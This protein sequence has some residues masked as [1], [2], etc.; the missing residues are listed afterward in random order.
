MAGT[1]RSCPCLLTPPLG[2]D[3]DPRKV[4]LSDRFYL[5]DFLGNTSVY[6]RGMPNPF[7]H[8]TKG[9]HLRNARVLCERVLD[10]LV[11]EIGPL[12]ISYGFISPQFSRATVTYQDPDIPSHHRWD[13]GAAAD[14]ISH[15]WVEGVLMHPYSYGTKTQICSSP[16][17]LAHML[18]EMELPYSRLITYSESPA[19]CVAV[20]AAEVEDGSPRRA[21]YENRYLGR[22]RT[23]PLFL[24]YPTMAAKHT[25][26]RSLLDVGLPAG[27]QGSG[28]PTYHGGGIRQYQHI[29]T[30]RYTVAL[31]WLFNMTSIMRGAKNILP[32]LDRRVMEAMSLAARAFDLVQARDEAMDRFS[33]VGGFV[34]RTHP[35]C[36]EGSNWRGS[37]IEFTL[38]AAGTLSSSDL[39]EYI[40]ASL[41]PRYAS[42]EAVEIGCNV[43]L[44]RQAA[45][46]YLGPS[47]MDLT[48]EI[49]L[50]RIIRR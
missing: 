44:D 13:L 30:G 5:S 27:W 48:H 18:H 16:I 37:Y 40:M 38:R 11:A 23:K 47:A 32:A 1:R 10:P 9:K 2:I 8:P 43:R 36:T 45:I 25:A 15:D 29:R 33:I 12:S 22:P 14:I 42:V 34:C 4:R 17:L 20:S 21:F 24:R 41:D 39:P 28:Y 46:E 7:T 50:R 49:G 31:D 6:A 3:M 35:D 19:I 26:L